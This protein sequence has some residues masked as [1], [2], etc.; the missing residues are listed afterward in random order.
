MVDGPGWGV[1]E[2]GEA[3]GS[4]RGDDG[5]DSS[6]EDIGR[7]WRLAGLYEVGGEGVTDGVEVA[8]HLAGG[9]G[10]GV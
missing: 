2:S 9:L 3:S 4:M 6:V 5:D 10:W 7:G 8:K 1:G